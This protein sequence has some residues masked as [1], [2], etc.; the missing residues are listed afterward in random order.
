M[1]CHTACP[2]CEGCEELRAEVARLR[3]GMEQ[4]LSLATDRQ[5][6]VMLGPRAFARAEQIARA[7]LSRATG[8]P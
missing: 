1:T 2:P 3:T 7:A 8:E 4:I 5:A 6:F